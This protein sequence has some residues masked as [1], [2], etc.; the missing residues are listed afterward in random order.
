MNSNAFEHSRHIHA[1]P[2][3]LCSL[4]TSGVMFSTFLTHGICQINETY[5]TFEI[6]HWNWNMYILYINSRIVYNAYENNGCHRFFTCSARHCLLSLLRLWFIKLVSSLMHG[7]GPRVQD[8]RDSNHHPAEFQLQLPQVTFLTPI[9][10]HVSV[11]A[12]WWWRCLLW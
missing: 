1:G 5:L 3:E 10:L 4:Q 9:S 11:H 12:V 7:D 6:Y 2:L 8:H